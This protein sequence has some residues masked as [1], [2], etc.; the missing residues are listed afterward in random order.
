[1]LTTSDQTEA[2]ALHHLP[3]IAQSGPSREVLTGIAS[4]KDRLPR[5]PHE[6]RVGVAPGQVGGE[7]VAPGKPEPGMRGFVKQLPSQSLV[8]LFEPTRARLR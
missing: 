8:V 6:W 4:E 5:N 1:M 7:E 3:T 2:G